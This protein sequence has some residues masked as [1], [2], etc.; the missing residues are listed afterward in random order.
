VLDLDYAEDSAADVDF[1]VVMTD[2]GHFV[3]L[4]GT[5]EGLPFDREMVDRLIDLAA[6]GIRELNVVQLG[7]LGQL[8]IARPGASA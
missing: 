3:E 7:A 6:A 8:G 5:A 4:Q 1:N 2:A